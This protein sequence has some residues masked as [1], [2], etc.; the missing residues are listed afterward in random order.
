VHHLTLKALL[1]L[2]PLVLVVGEAGPAAAVA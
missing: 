2:P 1:L